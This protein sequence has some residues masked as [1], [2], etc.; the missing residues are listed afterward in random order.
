MDPIVIGTTLTALAYIVGAIAFWKFSLARGFQKRELKWILF[1]ALTGGILGAK[2]SSLVLSL[3]HGASPAALLAH[4]DG[5]SIIGGILFGWL[6]VETAKKKLK[7][8]RS[9]GDGFAFALTLGE[10]VGRVGCFFSGCCFGEKATVPWAVFQHDALRHPTQIY[11][12]VLALL[13]FF[14]LLFLKNKVK[15]EGDLFRVYLL[16]YGVGRFVMEFFRVRSEVYFGLSMAQ[17]VSLE[18]AAGMVFALVWVYTRKT[19]PAE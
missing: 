18:I 1:A 4:P 14:L 9:T 6:G 2:F 11:S 8:T 13:V 3:L 15:Y 12:A 17:W 7:I 16:C 19:E 10:A 5:R